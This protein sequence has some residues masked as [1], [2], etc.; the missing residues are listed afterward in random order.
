MRRLLAR[1][2]RSRYWHEPERLHGQAE[3]DARL[4]R[5]RFF[6]YVLETDFGHYVGHTYHV[7]RRLR[8]HQRGEVQSTK[9]SSPSLLWVS[10][11]FTTREGAARFEASLKSLRDQHADRYSEIVGYDD[12][13]FVPRYSERP[14]H[15]PKGADLVAGALVAAVVAA[16]FFLSF[17]G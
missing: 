7:G 9:G 13:P 3:R 8:A 2:R 15:V 4:G 17:L 10:S 11:P 16:L 5:N 14:L 12:G 6:V 1:P